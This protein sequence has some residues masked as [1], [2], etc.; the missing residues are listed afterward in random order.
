[1]LDRLLHLL[2]EVRD[3]V[4]VRANCGEEENAKLAQK[5]CESDRNLGERQLERAQRGGARVAKGAN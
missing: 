1:M 4:L 2:H 5:T 3:V